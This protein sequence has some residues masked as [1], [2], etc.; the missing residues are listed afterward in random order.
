MVVSTRPFFSA[1]GLYDFARRSSCS[2]LGPE[3]RVLHAQRSE[4]AGLEEVFVG[5]AAHD[6]DDPARRVDAGVG[7]AV[8]AARLELERGHGV[9]PGS[10]AQGEQVERRLLDRRA[11]RQ[12][13]GVAE[14][15]AD[16]D[17]VLGL[18]EQH[19]V[20]VALHGQP[21]VL[22]LRQVGRHG[23]V[24]LHLPLVHQH[25]QGRGG[26][27]LRLRGDPEQGVGPHRLPGGD[28]GEA[29]GLEGQH[30]VLVRHERD[31]AGQRMAVHERLQTAASSGNRFGGPAGPARAAI[32]LARMAAMAMRSTIE[33][34]RFMVGPFPVMEC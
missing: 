2:S 5:H 26:D 24:E 20:L 8:L 29:D 30:L 21:L 25:H 16:R 6:L 33:V 23:F 31:C 4:Q 14:D 7:I 11:G 32:G 10:R 15:L 13:A 1:L 27:R 17:R 18:L 34:T 9:A 28:V 3:G 22:E 19:V 12:A